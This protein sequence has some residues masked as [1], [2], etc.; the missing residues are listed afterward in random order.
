MPTVNKYLKTKLK[1]YFY[2]RIGAK[3]YRNGW[4]KSACP[5]CE[6]DGKFGIHLQMNRCNCFR[7]GAHPSPIQLVMDLEKLDTYHDAYNFIINSEF[8]SRLVYKEVDVEIKEKR[9]NIFL[10]PG[11]RLITMGDSILARAARN[12]VKKRGFSIEEA[13]R[14]GWGYSNDEKYFG[15]LII[16]YIEEG[17]LVYFN[18]RLFMGSGPKYHNPDVSQ[19]GLGKSFLIYNKDALSIY[20][21]I[22]L[23]EGAINAATIGP[24][25]ISF[26]GK[27]VS[28]YQTNLLLKSSA[29]KFVIL[30]DPDAKDKAIELAMRLV[31]LK[32]V[33]VVFLPEGTDV[34][35]IGKA[36]TM[37]LVYKEH[38]LDYQELLSI[39]T[40]IQ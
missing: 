29:S 10:P 35:D 24:N 18:A 5:Y 4:T 11:F 16:P 20:D 39:K 27:A 13:A 14:M 7:C 19:T 38:Y 21:T 22:Y 3:D 2:Q 1:N 31:N 9:D 25:A 33:K 30:L 17:K 15:Y 28:Q 40:N 26:G 34:N 8:F 12:Y 37:N 32:K 6:A 36:K 23:C